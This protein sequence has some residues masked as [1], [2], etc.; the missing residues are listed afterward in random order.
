MSHSVNEPPPSS[1]LQS[2][3]SVIMFFKTSPIVVTRSFMRYIGIMMDSFHSIVIL[4]FYLLQNLQ[5]ISFIQIFGPT[6]VW[7]KHVSYVLH[8]PAIFFL[9]ITLKLYIV[10][11]KISSEIQPS[12]ILSVLGSCILFSTL[13]LWT[14]VCVLSLW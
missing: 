3:M 10:N 8:V 7:S 9:S 1:S 2:Q 11:D 14:T 12:I 13:F 5:E 6:F 4:F